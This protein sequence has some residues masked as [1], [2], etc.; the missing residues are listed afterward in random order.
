MPERPARIRLLAL[1]PP[2]VRAGGDVVELPPKPLAVLVYLALEPSRDTLRR[3]TLLATFWPESDASRARNSLNQVVHRLRKRLGHDV[4]ESRG[5]EEL[6]LNGHFDSDVE[7]FE[8]MV[9]D[10][11]PA[12]ALALYRGAFLEGFHVRNAP[13]FER[14]LDGVRARL[15]TRAREAA[16][17][18]ATRTEEAV[19]EPTTPRAPSTGWHSRITASGCGTKETNGTS[20]RS[21]VA[22]GI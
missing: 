5:D 4:L 12:R 9:D 1:G 10:G 20:V 19:P 2:E 17:G 6:G 22:R 3:D 16:L 8:T 11:R 15:T 13:R 14:W 18:A 7:Q 21:R